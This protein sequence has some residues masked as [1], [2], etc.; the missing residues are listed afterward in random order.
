MEKK[1]KKEDKFA[2]S[3]IAEAVYCPAKWLNIF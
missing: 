2:L 3:P 1:L